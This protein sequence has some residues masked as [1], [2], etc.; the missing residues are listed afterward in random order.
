MLRVLVAVLVGA[1][2]AAGC[3]PAGET[4]GGSDGAVHDGGVPDGSSV[5]VSPDAGCANPCAAEGVTVRGECEGSTLRY[6]EGDCIVER[7]CATLAGGPYICGDWDPSSAEYFECLASAG[8]PCEPNYRT[9]NPA[10]T[11]QVDCCNGNPPCNPSAA[12]PLHC[13]P[14]STVC[15]VVDGG[16][17][18]AAPADVALLDA[19]TG[20]ALLS[21]AAQPDAAQPDAALPDAALP[22][23]AVDDGWV[24]DA[25]VADTAVADQAAFDSQWPDTAA[26]DQTSDSA[27]VDAGAGDAP[28][29]DSEVVDGN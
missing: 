4:D 19:A 21:D 25:A 9:C 26:A 6:C 28:A 16:V 27:V 8:Q 14:Q 15:V 10:D 22:D 18:D 20:D 2:L 29:A 24:P 5:D 17:P 1:S 12:P 7:D 11:C 13:D 23:A 3:P